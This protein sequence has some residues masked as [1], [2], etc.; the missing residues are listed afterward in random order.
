MLSVMQLDGEREREREGEREREVG[1]RQ[2]DIRKR[3][4]VTVFGFF[5]YNTF[6]SFKLGI[7]IIH[8]SR[9]ALGG[10]CKLYQQVIHNTHGYLARVK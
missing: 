5:F 3:L 9:T 4:Y 1:V 10:T 6:A 2:E 7:F 8:T